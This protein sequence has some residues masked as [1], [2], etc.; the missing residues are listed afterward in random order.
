MI[1][2][3][4]KLAVLT[5][6]YVVMISAWFVLW[7]TI[8]DRVWWLVLVNRIVPYLFLPV[9]FFF[10]LAIFL[11]NFKSILPLL[12]PILI[13]ENLYHPYLLP[14]PAKSP[15]IDFQL[16]VMTYNVLYS[17]LD[18]D[19]VA[20]VILTSQPDLIAL[21]EVLPEM[22][23]ALEVR[24]ATHYP[25]SWREAEN[26]YGTPAIFSR[27]PFA[28]SYVLDLQAGR[29][30]VVVK[31]EVHDKEVTFVAAHLL[32]YGLQWVK[33]KD[34]PAAIMERTAN[35]NRQVELLLKQLK[36]E[37]GIVLLGCD[38]NSKETS[39]SYRMLDQRLNN[40]ARQVGWVLQ[41]SEL[42]HVRQDITLQHIDYVWYGG[43]LE[44]L[45]VYT[46]NDSGGSDHLPVLA[47]FALE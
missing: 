44:P 13:L 19:A 9:P 17:N 12:V 38:C 15:E 37:D 34:I 14:K 33:P 42:P 39:S 18:Y 30:A 20:N 29:P 25:Y 16:R 23:D 45:G 31:T 10:A 3:S 6:V 32:A 4:S 11:G 43:N 22:M 40:A 46:V 8:G 27:Y 35:Q 47:V 24:L 2:L 7:L 41:T 28:E 36:H 26:G 21:Q 5:L 1:K